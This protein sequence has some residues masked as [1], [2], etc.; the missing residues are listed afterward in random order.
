MMNQF[1]RDIQIDLIMDNPN[2]IIESFN[3]IWKYL[4]VIE[5]DVYHNN[6]GEF[7]YYNSNKEWVFFRD[8]KNEKF[9]CHYGRFW[10][11]FESKTNLNYYEIRDLTK[12]LIEDALNNNITTTKVTYYNGKA[13]VE[14]VLTNI[15]IKNPI[16]T[17]YLSQVDDLISSK[18]VRIPNPA[19]SGELFEPIDVL[20]AL[21][22]M[23][24]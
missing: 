21:D 23:V 3:G 12:I 11:F 5:I 9:W 13:A 22:N 14:N 20:K 10:A 8:D 4:S 7:I 18:I 17:E 15:N 19:A 2:P 24:K 6:G 16:N 1:I